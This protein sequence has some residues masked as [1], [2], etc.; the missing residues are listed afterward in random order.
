MPTFLGKS[1]VYASVGK[2]LVSSEDAIGSVYRLV[3]V[4]SQARL[5]RLQLVADEIIGFSSASLGLYNP[6]NDTGGDG[7]VVSADLFLKGLDFSEQMKGPLDVLFHG[8]GI[9]GI[10]KRVW[11]LLGLKV[12]PQISYDLCVTSYNTPS[13]S[14]EIAVSVEF[15][16]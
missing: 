14:G 11:E 4:P 6:Q 13:E 8:I 5:T 15:V 3:R 2:A 7:A 10:E 12:D 9:S 1:A 16:I